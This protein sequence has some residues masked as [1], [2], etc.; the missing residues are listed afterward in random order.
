MAYIDQTQ[1][2]KEIEDAIRGN[3]VSNVAP[4]AVPNDVQLVLDVNPKNYRRINIVRRAIGAGTIYT[5]PNNK[6]FF[7]VST[8]I[9]MDSTSAASASA[10]TIQVIPEGETTAIIINGVYGKTTALVDSVNGVSNLSFPI[11]MKLA[12]NTAITA[13]STNATDREYIIF[14]YTVEL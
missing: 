2:K 4:T 14:G 1:T 5:T 6:D 8:H 13:N 12:R 11:P 3:S 7:L 10:C 9:T